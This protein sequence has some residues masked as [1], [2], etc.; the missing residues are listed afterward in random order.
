MQ[1]MKIVSN[2]QQG[3]RNAK[4]YRTQNGAWGVIVFDA[5]DNYEAFASFELEEQAE[6][7]AEDWVSGHVSI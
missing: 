7:F 2:Y 3:T 1:L 4:V 5:S 6:N